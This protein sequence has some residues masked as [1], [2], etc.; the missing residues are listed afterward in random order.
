MKIVNELGDTILIGAL[1]KDFRGDEAKFISFR[2]PHK[3]SSTGSVRVETK[4]GNICDF[5]PGVYN[6]KIVP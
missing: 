6:L 1:L 4:K 3:S 5:Y 2:Q